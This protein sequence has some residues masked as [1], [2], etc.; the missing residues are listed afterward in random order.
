MHEAHMKVMNSKIT[1]IKK[2]IKFYNSNNSRELERALLV[3]AGGGF[4]ERRRREAGD[5]R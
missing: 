5:G 4:Q 3:G 2:N 1:Q